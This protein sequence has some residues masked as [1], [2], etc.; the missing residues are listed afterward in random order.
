MQGVKFGNKQAFKIV[1]NDIKNNFKNSIK[2]TC[3]IEITSKQYEFLN[4]KNINNLNCKNYKICINTFGQKYLLY[5]TKYKNAKYCIFINRK[6]EDMIFLRMSFN[7]EL[8]LGTLFD[9]EL[10]KNK[11]N[12]WIYAISDI[13]L[14]KGQNTFD[15]YK[16]DERYN[17]MINIFNNEYE[18]N[19][20]VDVCKID[21]KKYFTCEYLKDI[22]E[23]YLPSVPYKYSGIFFHNVEIN[24][25]DKLG[26]MY[27]FPEFRT[28]REPNKIPNNKNN[29]SKKIQ[30]FSSKNEEE[31]D[32]MELKEPDR[33]EKFRFKIKKTDLPD[34]YGL[35]Y[36]NNGKIT[37]Y[38]YA[39]VPDMVTSK[40]LMDTF[41]K[42]DNEDIEV[43]VECEY[44]NILGRWIPRKVVSPKYS[45]DSI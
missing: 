45:M 44:S 35:Y 29:V 24:K 32:D 15:I 30:N 33:N 41:D 11:N 31:D 14:Y 4:E 22:Y 17:L 39:G 37:K 18:Y 36:K 7:E 25:N 28:T 26:Y 5:L 6:K 9:G 16:I 12:E 19:N 13:F 40:L 27:I 21:V 20:D 8:Y 1:S 34:V 42:Y 43:V 23:N 3:G 38:G 10:I 2:K